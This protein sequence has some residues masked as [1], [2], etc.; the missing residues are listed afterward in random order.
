MFSSELSRRVVFLRGLYWVSLV[1]ELRV[2]VKCLVAV[3]YSVLGL[4]YIIE[5]HR[6]DIAEGNFIFLDLVF[7]VSHSTQIYAFARVVLRVVSRLSCSFG[8]LVLDL[9][10]MVDYHLVGLHILGVVQLVRL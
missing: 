6:S 7:V 9:L 2:G 8:I 1:V 10:H 5:N 3:L 4:F